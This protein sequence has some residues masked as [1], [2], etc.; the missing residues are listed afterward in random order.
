MDA[1]E[2]ARQEAE[3]IYYAAISLGD[4]PEGFLDLVQ[5]EASRRNLDVYAVM[6]GDPQLKG[7]KATFDSQAGIILFENV[8]SDFDQAFLIAHELGHVVLEGATHDVVTLNVEQDCSIEESGIGIAKVLDYGS[9]ERRE[10][11]MDIFARELLLPR[12]VL[13]NLYLKDQHSSEAIA[14][15]L[16]APIQVIQQQLLD[17]L[18]LPIQKNSPE[19]IE[20]NPNELIPD[21]TQIEAAT[22]RGSP[23]LLQAG[24]GT[25]KTRTLVQR[26]ESLIAEGVDPTSILV[27]T[28]SNKAA[29]ELSE[30]IAK[31]NPIAGAA[32]W[33]GTFHAFG[34]D[35][36]RRF[37]DKLDF[38]TSPRL[39]DR[40]EAIELLEYELPRLSFSHFRNLWDPALDLNDM[41]HAISRSKDEVVD[42]A[43]YRRLAQAMKDRSNEDAESMT[44]AEKCL[45]VALLFET[46]ERLMKDLNLIDFGDLVSKPV[47]LVESDLDVRALLKARHRH[48]LVDEYQDVNRASARL[49]KAIAGDGLNLWVVGDARQS[50]Y[51]FR[52][53]SSTNMRL[54]AQDFPATKVSQLE[55]N[56]RSGQE[57]IDVFKAFS[58]T[59]KAS[60]GALPLS[61]SAA[62]GSLNVAQELLIAK[63]TDDEISAIAAAVQVQKTKGIEYRKQALLCVSNSRLSEIAEGLEARGVPVLHLGSLFERSEIRDLLAL[64]SMLTDPHAL[65]LM[66]VAQMP[67]YK[68]PL[69]DVVTII[70]HLKASN[71]APLDWMQVGNRLSAL[72]IHSRT[73][74]E[75]ISRLFDGLSLASHPWKILATWVLDGLGLAKGFQQ[76]T[77]VKSQIKCIG[78]WQLLNF[79]R[80]QPQRGGLPSQRLLDRIRRMVLLAEDRGLRQ[81]PNVAEGIDAVRLMTIHASKGLEFDVVH[82]PS[83]VTSSLPRNNRPPRCLPPDGLIYGSN[84]ITGLDAVKAG[85]EE[86]EECVFFVALSRARSQVLLY[87]SSVQ[88][89]GKKRNLSK[90]VIPIQSLLQT[91]SSP[92]LLQK[93]VTKSYPLAIT[94]EKKPVW[95]DKQLSLFEKCPRRFLYTY[96][97]NLGARST[98]TAFMKMHNVVRETLGWLKKD[99]EITAPDKAEV[100]ANFERLWQLKGPTDH[101][102]ASDYHRIGYRL[103]DYVVEKRGSGALASSAPLSLSYA[104]GDVSVVPDIMLRDAQGQVVVKR[105]KTGKANT[106]PFDAIEFTIFHL[107]ASQAYGANVK[108]EVIYL[109]SEMDIPISISG[110]KYENRR[111]K[112][113]SMLKNIYLGM[114]PIAPEARSCPQCPHFF[115]CGNLPTGPIKK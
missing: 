44:R 58:N 52:G 106:T 92:E 49:L 26:V 77:D 97:L 100:S 57:V 31:Y 27:L 103:V 94:W 33:I 66:R 17:A 104:D 51:R 19:P 9:H 5:R 79:C 36:I 90:F 70:E 73:T 15:L 65:G 74:L 86:E 99:H 101:G 11:R 10:V 91:T 35:I 61:L 6:A 95:T 76:V 54:Y 84:E 21:Q 1:I 47:Q 22:H 113:T 78:L 108:A 88:S 37:H 112:L 93:Q 20:S 40:M 7:G 68:M 89:D 60:I 28:F 29:N 3:R 80:R 109:T 45:E 4:K 55:V 8:G 46:Y 85:H 2:A 53:A 56:Y 32:M 63:T 81:L 25:G 83:L 30:R 111:N 102:Y 14:Q 59:M 62:R 12:S 115:I 23:F 18:L 82:I 96:L 38:S 98:D 13:R 64:L 71:A 43:E 48:V 75:K 114:F 105:I 39:I 69:H 24:P 34:L 41:L 42:A 87:A 67:N 110:T 50:I 16:G 72:D 107:A